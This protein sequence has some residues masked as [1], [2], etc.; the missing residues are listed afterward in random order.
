MGSADGL[1]LA[2]RAI[3]LKVSRRDE[4]GVHGNDLIEQAFDDFL[5]DSVVRNPL[6]SNFFKLHLNRL[7]QI[8]PAQENIRRM[9]MFYPSLVL[10]MVEQYIERQLE[11]AN[12]LRPRF[13]LFHVELFE[14]DLQVCVVFAGLVVKDEDFFATM[15]DPV[16]SSLQT[17]RG[18]RGAIRLFQCVDDHL[19]F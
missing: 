1:E 11:R 6:C 16:E 15:L 10:R 17:I 13:P 4:G 2:L 9:N 18:E 19:P 12:C 8:V 7:I 3:L 14:I 5:H